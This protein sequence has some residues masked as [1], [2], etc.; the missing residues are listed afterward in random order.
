[1]LSVSLSRKHHR[2][3]APAVNRRKPGTLVAAVEVDAGPDAVFAALTDWERQGEWL[4]ATTVV[5]CRQGGIGVGGCIVARTG[6]GPLAI[7]DT[8][9][10]VEWEPPYRCL[11][12]HTGRV[13][14]GSGAFVVVPLPAGRSRLV[15]SEELD[16]L[17]GWF[18]RAVFELLRPLLAGVWRVSLHRFARNVTSS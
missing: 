7:V 8:M 6:I 1:M 12:R 14:R 3:P 18:G 4:L 16:L 2:P 15:W 11:V 9:E 10:I 17:L 13:V 5:R